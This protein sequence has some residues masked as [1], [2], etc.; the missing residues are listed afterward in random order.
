MFDTQSF[1][2][3]TMGSKPLISASALNKRWNWFQA[4]TRF[5]CVNLG[6]L[7]NQIT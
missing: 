6:K 2:F 4:E 7:E 3:D 5:L 1:L